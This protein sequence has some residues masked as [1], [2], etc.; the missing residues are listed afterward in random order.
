MLPLRIP[1]IVL[2]CAATTFSSVIPS[3]GEHKASNDRIQE[4]E[5]SDQDHFLDEMHNTEYD[6]E[7]FLGD[8]ANTFNDLSPEES[9]E[10]LG[11]IYEKIDKDSDGFVSEEELIEWI[12]HVQNRYIEKDTVRQW[13]EFKLEDDLLSFNTYKQRTYGFEEEN[14]AENEDDS[15]DYKDMLTRDKRRWEMADADQDGKLS[16]TEFSHFLHPEE[17][18]HM[19]GVVIDETLED[20][21]KDKDGRISLEEYIADMWP[22]EEDEEPDWVKTEREQFMEF[23]DKNKDG[24]M[25]QQEVQDWII[26]PDY[27]HSE[28]EGKHLI[29]EADLDR[30]GKLTKEEVLNKYDLFVGS[31][32]TDF[33]EA[34]MRHDEF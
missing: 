17:Q 10:K 13:A 9:K 2:L 4:K 30:D 23:R 18:E 24:Y 34:L 19:R 21:D 7:A 26:P 31:Q 28:A 5:L 1:V 22:Q 20:I 16:K 12:K 33:G 29:S 8:E 14:D 27:D 15:Y 32:A 25:D 6:H 11:L 3:E